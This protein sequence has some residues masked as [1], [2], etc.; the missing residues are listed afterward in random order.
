MPS[1]ADAGSSG[2]ASSSA[3]ASSEVG[4]DAVGSDAVVRRIP[5]ATIVIAAICILVQVWSAMGPSDEEIDRLLRERASIEQEILHEYALLTAPNLE[6]RQFLDAFH[7]GEDGDPDDELRDAYQ[8]IRQQGRALDQR[9][10]VFMMGYRPTSNNPVRMVTSAFVHAGWIHLLGNLLFLYLVGCNLE[11]RWTKA[12][13]VAF[14]LLGAIVSALSYGLV[15]PGSPVPLVGASGAVSA[16]M[17]AFVVVM[18]TAQIRFFYLLWVFVHVRTGNFHAKA[19]VA[20]PLWFVMQFLNAI[21]EGSGAGDGVAYSAHVGGFVF[22]AAV[23]FLC[24][25]HAGFITGQ[26]LLIDGGVFRGS[27]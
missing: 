4:S 19:Y 5:W 27:F 6:Q 13:F 16:A 22:G 18:G 15:H 14:Y 23:A 1:A 24:S 8:A 11:D 12:G 10:P 3:V 17:G 7:D 25:Q 26:N 9:S 2:A 21:L 20:L